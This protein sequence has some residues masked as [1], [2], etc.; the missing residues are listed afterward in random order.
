VASGFYN[1]ILITALSSALTTVQFAQLHIKLE[2]LIEPNGDYV[3]VYVLDAGA[4][5]ANN[6]IWLL[7]SR[8]EQAIVL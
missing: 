4:L 8:Q 2:K 1:G 5:K 3:Q 7:S 6:C